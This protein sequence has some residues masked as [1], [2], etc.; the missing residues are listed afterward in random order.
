MLYRKIFA[1]SV[2]VALFATNLYAQVQQVSMTALT[3]ANVP[4]VNGGVFTAFASSVTRQFDYR[5]VD[6]NI[7]TF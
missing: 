7:Y 6:N 2:L 4:P 3:G 1:I 5:G